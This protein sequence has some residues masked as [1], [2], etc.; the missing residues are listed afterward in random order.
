MARD[1]DQSVGFQNR[2][3]LGI[4]FI[5]V[6]M[7]CISVNDMLIK[8]LSGSYPLHEMVFVRSAIGILFS[9]LILQF[10]G[11]IRMLR[12]DKPGLHIV[13]GLFIVAANMSFFAALA[14]MPLAEATAMFFVAPLFITLLSIPFLGESVGVRRLSAVVV[15]FIGVLVMLRPGSFVAQPTADQIILVLPIFAAFAYACMQILTRRLG[16]SSTASAMAIYIQVTFVVVSLGFW[17]VAGD[18]QYAEGLENRSAL[19]LLRAW[20]YPSQS[21]WPWFILLGFTSAIIGYS[22]SQAYRSADAATIAPFEYVALPMSIMWGWAIF[23]ELPDVWVAVGI[24]LIGGAGFYVF[25]REKQK[26]RPVAGRRP[27]RRY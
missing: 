21:D 4:G 3:S 24:C 7:F 9:L 22:L 15:G 12:T 2:T 27:V 26:A 6:G 17:C 8:Q 5:L 16:V 10:E 13:R 1:P 25:L 11:G 23:G 18:G 20:T 14:A 19:F